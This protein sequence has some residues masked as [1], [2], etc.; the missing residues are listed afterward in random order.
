MHNV[1]VCSVVPSPAK[2]DGLVS[3]TG[4]SGNSRDLDETHE[5]MTSDPDDWRTRLICCLENPDHI[6]NRKV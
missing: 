5:M 6:A 3:E 1:T 4:G 2:L